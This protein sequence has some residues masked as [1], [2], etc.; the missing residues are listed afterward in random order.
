MF[1]NYC[2]ISEFIV[3]KLCAVANSLA[4]HAVEQLRSQDNVTV[5]VILITDPSCQ[6]VTNG[7][8]ETIP[9]SYWLTHDVKMIGKEVAEESDVDVALLTRRPPRQPPV[10]PPAVMG[11]AVERAEE[12]DGPVT[13][14]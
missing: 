1:C 6:R 12:V 10:A 7:L 3:E 14:T 4:D 2:T 11:R 8:I 13:L 5:M 9:D